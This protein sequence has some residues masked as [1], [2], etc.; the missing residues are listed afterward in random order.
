MAGR[1]AKLS[2]ED[3]YELKVLLDDKA[4]DHGFHDD[5]WSNAKIREVIINRFGV[6]YHPAYIGKIRNKIEKTLPSVV[7]YFSN[8]IV[9]LYHGDAKKVLSTLRDAS[10][11]SIVTSPPYYG[12]RDYGVVGQIGLE[13][14]PQKYVDNLVSIFEEAKEY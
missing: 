10:V 2:K 1:K 13:D 4:T 3:L 6:S 14:H 8:D 11:D 7:H 5:K 9:T 12:Q